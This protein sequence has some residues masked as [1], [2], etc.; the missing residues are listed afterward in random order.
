MR[1]S[2]REPALVFSAPSVL[3]SAFSA[4]LSELV[5]LKPSAVL[6]FGKQH[7]W[8]IFIFTGRRSATAHLNWQLAHVLGSDHTGVSPII[9]VNPEEE[10]AY[11]AEWPTALFCIVPLADRG[12]SFCRW[13][14]HSAF[15]W[16]LPYYW[17]F[18]DNIIA[19]A[20]VKHGAPSS[21]ATFRQAM[22]HVQSLPDVADYALCGFLRATGTESC[23]VRQYVPG[24]AA[25][26]KVLLVNTRECGSCNYVAQLCKWEDIAFAHDLWA[27]GRRFLKVQTFAYHAVTTKGGGCAPQRGSDA[28]VHPWA[29]HPLPS[30]AAYVVQRLTAWLGKHNQKSAPPMLRTSCQLNVKASSAASPTARAAALFPSS[31]APPTARAAPSLSSSDMIVADST[32]SSS[33]VVSDDHSDAHY[34]KRLR[35]LDGTQIRIPT[36]QR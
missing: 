9:V 23:K 16:R 5:S 13:V 33:F 8:P 21:P 22:L 32:S 14:I 2:S 12:I 11:R 10:A 34:R 15:S 7:L 26:Y 31:S 27:A 24:N 35:R 1:S 3:L 36:T 25:I 20:A 18:D 17:S 28:L 6:Q 19:F 4:E 29:V 30:H